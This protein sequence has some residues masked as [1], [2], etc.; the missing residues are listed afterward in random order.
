MKN[1]IIVKTFEVIFLDILQ[2]I[3]LVEENKL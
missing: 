3:Q 1:L 2:I